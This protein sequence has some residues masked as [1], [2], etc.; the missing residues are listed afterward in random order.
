[1]RITGG[2]L[3]F[4]CLISPGWILKVRWF[5]LTFLRNLG[6]DGKGNGKGENGLGDKGRVGER[7]RGSEKNKIQTLMSMGAI[8]KEGDRI[9]QLV[10]ERVSVLFLKWILGLLGEREVLIRCGA[11][12]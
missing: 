2:W 7:E 6:T 12:W 1:M 9:A 10:L 4:C 8:V 3:R 11:R 5:S